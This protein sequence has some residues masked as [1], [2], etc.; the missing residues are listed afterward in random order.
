MLSET[1]EIKRLRACRLSTAEV[2]AIIIHLHQWYSGFQKLQPL[3][4]WQPAKILANILW[5]ALR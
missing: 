5:K 2:M 1:G 3:L 4:C